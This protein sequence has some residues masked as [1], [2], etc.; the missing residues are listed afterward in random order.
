[1]FS[2]YNWTNSFSVIVVLWN[3]VAQNFDLLPNTLVAIKNARV[4]VANGG[5]GIAFNPSTK[6][7]YVRLILLFVNEK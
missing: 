6:I 3:E 4:Q 2:S 1:M 5:V 7:E